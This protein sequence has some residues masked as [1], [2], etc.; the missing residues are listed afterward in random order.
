MRSSSQI[1][2]WVYL[3][4]LKIGVSV[5]YWEFVSQLLFIMLLP[6]AH[7]SNALPWDSIKAFRHLAA[8]V[9]LNYSHIYQYA[10]GEALY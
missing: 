1:L 4:S 3:L 8:A 2:S 10:N 6:Q 7:S 5:I 9:I